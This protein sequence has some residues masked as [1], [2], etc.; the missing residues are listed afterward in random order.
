VNQE[1]YFGVSVT[2]PIKGCHA[3]LKAYLKHNRSDLRGVFVKLRLFWKAQATAI[4]TTSAQ[5][6]LRPKHNTNIPLF[7]AIL[8]HVHGYTLQKIL[9]EK[10]KIPAQVGP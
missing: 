1:L 2:S 3:T 4:T 8:Q 6:Q 5:Q 10:A 7:A 9:L